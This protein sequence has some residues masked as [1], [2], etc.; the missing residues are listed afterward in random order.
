M[1]EPPLD[2]D[3]AQ[4][5]LLAL[6][7]PGPSEIVSLAK[8]LGHYL[9]AAPVA[10]LSRPHANLS[11]M[12]GF[13]TSG[14]GPWAVVGESRCGSA[15]AE[16]LSAGQ[17]VRISTGAEI[18]L[19]ADA[20]VIKEEAQLSGDRL[21]ATELPQPGRYI[22]RAGEDFETG[23]ELLDAGRRMGAAQLSLCKAAGVD[24]VAVF[25][26][27]RIVVLECG[28]EL[29]AEPS[30]ATN[31]DML[32]AMFSGEHATVA[33]EPPLPDD[34]ETISRALASHRDA[35]LIVISGGASV[36]DHDLVRPALAEIG[37]TIDF[38]RV[39]MKPGKPLMVATRGSQLILGLPGNPVSSFVTG[40]L[41]ALPA[42]R[43]MAGASDPFPK[44][45]MRPCATALP[46]NGKRRQFLR[47]RTTANGSVEPLENQ[48]SAALHALARAD[49]LIDRPCD[50]GETK[51]G[52][53][54]PVYPLQ[55]GGIA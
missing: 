15:F 29:I 46:A 8:S 2:L 4:R 9:A 26:P 24:E 28:D 3:E 44:V 47:A 41:F 20:I 22:R 7:S 40:F 34:L 32:A 13:A 11:A 36:G 1:A 19:G 5:R 27:P 52:T 6:V 31:G 18:P 55:N 10:R 51:S 49:C 43:A 48:D 35:D 25:K 12:D 16:A 42:V 38:W 14:D 45:T 50:A 39:A 30:R 23:E 53:P 21:S 37:A 17:A 54:V 33:V